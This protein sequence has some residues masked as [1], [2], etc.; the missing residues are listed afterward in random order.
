MRIPVT[1]LNLPELA[2]YRER[3]ETQLMHYYEPEP[4]LFIAE[5]P[6]VILR[7]LDAGFVPVS[8]LVDETQTETGETAEVLER[9]GDVPV[10]TAS[11]KVLTELVGYRMI[12]GLLCMMQRGKTLSVEEVL[13]G[14]T[15]IAILERVTNPTNVGAILRSAAALD[16]D[17]VLLSA[18]CSDPYYRRASR[19]SMGNVFLLPWA[20]LGKQEACAERI[21]KLRSEGWT[22]AAMALS[23]EAVLLGDEKLSG[24]EKLAIVLGAEGEGLRPK[25]IAA[26]DMTVATAAPTTPH[27]NAATNS[28]SSPM[29]MTDEIIKK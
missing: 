12:R 10:Y 7:A 21:E 24:A 20:Y 2:L 16:I 17:A 22:T 25:T 11:E 28:R 9:I 3:A 23:E 5:S 18:D 6:K 19:V 15:R 14:A 29:F 1:D 4:G 26:C 8:A 13:Q 27:L